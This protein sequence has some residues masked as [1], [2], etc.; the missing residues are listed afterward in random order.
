MPSLVKEVRRIARACSNL[1]YEE[2]LKIKLSATT[3]YR[4][5]HHVGENITEGIPDMHEAID[6][7]SVAE[8]S[9]LY[10]W[11][12]AVEI[13]DTVKTFLSSIN[14]WDYF[15][16]LLYWITLLQGT[17][18]ALG[19]PLHGSNECRAHTDNG[20]VPSPCVEKA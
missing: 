8:L 5:Y 13:K 3:G 4:G 16:V 18:G 1:P 10:T 2:K 20:K 14:P 19:E 12:R 11:Q 9:W 17:C 6:V 15:P 7:A